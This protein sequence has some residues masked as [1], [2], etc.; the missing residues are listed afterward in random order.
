[1]RKRGILAFF[2]SL[3]VASEAL[4]VGATPAQAA[5]TTWIS[6]KTPSGAIGPKV[7]DVEA[8]SKADRGRVHL[9]TLRTSG[10]VDNQRWTITEIVKDSGV[11]QIRNVNSDKCLDKSEDAPDANGTPV[12]QYTCQT[13]WIT[14]QAWQFVRAVPGSNWG[15][16]KNAS[17]GRCLDVRGK[18]FTDGASLQVWDCGGDWNQRFN[19]F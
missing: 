7:L 4:L 15:Y 17:G 16:L 5:K 1:M 6:V 8:W 3:L 18:S 19:I 12:Y 10:N 11:Y 13:G 9:W 2:T 14:N